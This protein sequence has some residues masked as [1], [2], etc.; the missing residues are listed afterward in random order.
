MKRLK[1]KILEDNQL[2]IPSPMDRPIPSTSSLTDRPTTSALSP[3]GNST[4]NSWCH[5]SFLSSHIIFIAYKCDNAL[6]LLYLYI[7][8][9]PWTKIISLER[10]FE[11]DYCDMFLLWE[12]T[13]LLKIFHNL[14]S[15]FWKIPK[16]KIFFTLSYSSYL[17]A[18]G[19]NY[20]W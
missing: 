7:V 5:Y 11:K 3:T 18:L 9:L 1:E 2:F 19:F 16:T 10:A 13:K 4:G 12:S 6:P 20:H 17:L 15:K 14:L 8:C